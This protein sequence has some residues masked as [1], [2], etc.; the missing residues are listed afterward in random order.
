MQPTLDGFPDWT[1]KIDEVSAGVYNLITKHRLGPC[2]DLTGTDPDKLLARARIAAEVIERE[3]AQ[4]T[5]G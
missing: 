5:R 2:I 1:V 4:K 3:I